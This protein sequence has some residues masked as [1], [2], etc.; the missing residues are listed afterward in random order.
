[1]SDVTLKVG[2]E[3]RHRDPRWPSEAIWREVIAVIDGFPVVRVDGK[4]IVWTFEIERRPGRP[5]V[6]EQWGYVV[7]GKFYACFT[8]EQA[9]NY[10]VD[11]SGDRFRPQLARICAIDVLTPDSDEYIRVAI[12]CDEHGVPLASGQQS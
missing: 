11:Q 6:D 9:R 8:E 1:M 3:I 2:D 10:V 12:I 4:P 7:S 5:P